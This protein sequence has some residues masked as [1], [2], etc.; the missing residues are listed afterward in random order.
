MGITLCYAD[1]MPTSKSNI[2]YANCNH[3]GWW[4]FGEVQQ[5]VADSQGPLKPTSRCLVWQNTRILRAAD[6]EEAYRKAIQFGSAGIPSRDDS[7]EWRFVGISTLLPIHDELEDG[8]EISWDYQG[9]MSVARI[10]KLVKTKK[11]L[12]VFKDGSATRKRK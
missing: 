12:S 2:P 10:K 7:V 1:R 9:T 6:R 5:R 11:Q 4:I 3:T 8:A